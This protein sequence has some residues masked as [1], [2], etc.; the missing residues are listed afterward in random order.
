MPGASALMSTTPSL[1]QQVAGETEEERRKRLLAMSTSK[2][3]P[4]VSSILGTG[5]GSALGG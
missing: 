3:Q 1:A 4:G 5:Y 2:Q